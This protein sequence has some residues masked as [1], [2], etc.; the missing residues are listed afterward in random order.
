MSPRFS[1]IVPCYRLSG[2]RLLIEQCIASIAAQQFTDYE[3]LLVDDGS[4]DETPQ[5]LVQTLAAH[6]GL[7]DRGRLLVLRENGGVCASRNAGIEAARGDYI[8]FLDFDDLWQPGYLA[9]MQDATIR[10]PDTLVFLARTDFLRTMD[11]ELRV[12]STGTIGYL[13]GL[14]DICFDA[15]HLL[16]DFPVG[17]GSA[18]V[19]ARHLYAQHPDLKFDLALTRKTAED[20]LFGLQLLARG[21]RPW[22]VDEPLCV[23]RRI[24]GAISR[25]TAATL[26]I[27][28]RQVMDYLEERA[29]K[30]LAAKIVANRPELEGPLVARRNRLIQQFDLKRE[31]LSASR[32][33]GLGTC[34]RDPRGFKTLARLIV[35]RMLLGSPFAFLLQRYWFLKGGDDGE[36]RARVESL[37]RTIAPAAGSSVPSAAAVP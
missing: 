17:M 36:A 14:D 33:F 1:V 35:T 20:I 2:R 3:L 9:R 19:I 25:G 4:P 26:W 34:L 10:H 18:V 16:N 8:A 15:W 6:P 32:W 22:Y 11:D 23:H 30:S 7:G 29:A 21:I 31:Y 37:L 27:D 5:I 12:R 13:N 24:M 28:E